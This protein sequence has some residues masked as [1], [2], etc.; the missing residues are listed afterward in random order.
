MAA[1]LRERYGT[2]VTILEGD[3]A[4]PGTGQ[5][6]AAE[7]LAILGTVDIVV[8]NAGGPPPADPTATDAAAWASAF[9]LLA[10]TPIEL[11]T[12]LLPG[13]RA[14]GWGRV[15]GILSSGV[16][17]PIPDLV[18]SN[19]GRGALTAWLKTT[20]R[21]VAADGVTVNGVLPG[22]LDTPRIDSLDRG[23][24]ER[25]GQPLDVVGRATWRPSRP[26]ATGDRRS[27]ATTSPT[28]APRQRHT[29]RGRSRRSM[30]AWSPA[31]PD[32]LE[33]A[34]SIVWGAVGLD[35]DRVA[36]V[37][38]AI[39]EEPGSEPR[40]MNHRL[41]DRLADLLLEV[42]ARLTQPEPLDSDGADPERAADQ[43]V[44]SDAPRRQVSPGLARGKL[45]PG[46]GGQPLDLLG[47]DEGH[48]AAGAAAR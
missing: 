36:D 46:L 38:L 15:V 44:E 37:E 7:A 29:R 2:E 19:A 32:A 21:A 10:I 17:Q 31:C 12:A 18:Y 45:D 13:M 22:R 39:V 40:P 48:V 14:R 8:L 9:Q 23:R 26:V 4:Q 28:S 27:S 6:I 34:P 1:D 16:R 20:A 43:V 42:G 47:L 33:G 35:L 41:Q 24:A 11:A 30:G 5:R 3:A 25:T